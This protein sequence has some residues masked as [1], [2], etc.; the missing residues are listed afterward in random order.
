MAN[1]VEEWHDL[2]GKMVELRLNGRL[3]RT[4]EVEEVTDNSAFLWLR[5]CG[6]DPRQLVAKSDGYTITPIA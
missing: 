4:A 5:F 3:I 1:D 2:V 6:A